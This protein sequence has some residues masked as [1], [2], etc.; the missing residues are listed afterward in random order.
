MLTV[1]LV[2][3]SGGA[4]A[5]GVRLH[6]DAF[7]PQLAAAE[8]G[9]KKVGFKDGN[10]MVGKIQNQTAEK[11]SLEVAGG[12]MDFPATDIAEISDVTPEEIKSGTYSE[13]IMAKSST[14]KFMTYRRAD[15]L[16]PA[17]CESLYKAGLSPRRK[18]PGPGLALRPA[19]PQKPAASAIPTVTAT[20]PTG[21]THAG[22]TYM[23]TVNR[24]MSNQNAALQAKAMAEQMQS[25]PRNPFVEA[26]KYGNKKDEK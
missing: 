18:L 20:G 8:K 13:W 23:Q 17:L 15:C 5:M 19:T 24:A 9:Y 6:P 1:M 11:L 12:R 4:F 26:L 3:F 21:N 25:A 14:I 10:F 7:F 22:E 16:V 2:L